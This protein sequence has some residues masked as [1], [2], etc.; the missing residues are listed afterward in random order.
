LGPEVKKRTLSVEDNGGFDE[1]AA[2]GTALIGLGGNVGDPLAYCREAVRTL[3]EHPHVRLVRCSSF[4][5]TEPVGKI[6]QSWF[7]NG[8]ALCS[9]PLQPEELL[10]LLQ[11]LE[12]RC[13]RVRRERW[14]PRSLDLDLL[15]FGRM[16]LESERLTL[17]HPR[18]HERRFVLVPLLEIAP[19]WR[20]PVFGRTAREL[21]DA[22]DGV[23]GQAVEFLE[24]P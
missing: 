14:G 4:Y 23:P 13:G 3:A 15:S 22:L 10:A 20:H 24:S 12:W 6:D 7:V 5:R 1:T 2:A 9:T 8:A 18:I 21:L 19:R 17:P 11:E 16:V